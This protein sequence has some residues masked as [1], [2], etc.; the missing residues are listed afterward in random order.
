MQLT[1]CPIFHCDTWVHIQCVLSTFGGGGV[2]KEGCGHVTCT[3]VCVSVCV[4]YCFSGVWYERYSSCRMWHSDLPVCCEVGGSVSLCA[5]D[6][7]LRAH[8][9]WHGWYVTR[10]LPSHTCMHPATGECEGEE[11]M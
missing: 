8:V 6:P 3:C 9:H 5:C 4:C 2:Y 11:L 7:V 10:A 1:V